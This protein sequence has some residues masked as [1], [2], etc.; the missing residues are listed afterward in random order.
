MVTRLMHTLF[1]VPCK[2]LFAGVFLCPAWQPV[3]KYWRRKENRE[4]GKEIKLCQQEL[5]RFFGHVREV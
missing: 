4:K 2:Q 3:D 1:T 5:S